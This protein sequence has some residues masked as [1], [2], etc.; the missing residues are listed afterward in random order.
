M[1]TPLPKLQ[2]FLLC[3]IQLAEPVTATV[4][5]PY[6]VQLIRETGI[7]GGDERKVGHYAGVLV[8]IAHIAIEGRS[9]C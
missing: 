4:V 2:L 7:T 8:C 9:K 1:R 6:V 5:Y 3:C